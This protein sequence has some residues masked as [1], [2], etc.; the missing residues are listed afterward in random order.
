[1]ANLALARESQLTI[2][3]VINK[4]D[5][6]TADPQR[7][8]QQ[9]RDTLGLTAQPVLASAKE[10][11][12]V[13]ELLE[14]IV[15]DIPPPRGTATA[16]LQALVFDSRFD[17]YKGVVIY[18]RV[19]H[20]TLTPA[21]PVLLMGT[22]RAGDVQELG[23]LTPRPMAVQALSAGE[24]GYLTCNVKDPQDV[25]AGDTITSA[26]EPAREPLPGYKPVRPLVF[27]S[28][29]TVNAK[30]FPALR[31]ALQKLR[32]SDASFLFEPETSGP[33]GFGFRCGFLGLLH[34]EIIQERLEREF[35]LSLIATTPSVVYR[36]RRRHGAPCEINNPAQLPPPGDVTDIEEPTIRAV[37]IVPAESQGSVMHLAQE[38]RGVYKSTQYLGADRVMLVYK[39]PLIEV[40]VDFH[41]R[42]KS[43]TRGYG[44]MDYEFLG[45]ASAQLVKLDILLN[46][47]PC[48]ALASIVP[49]AKAYLRGRDLVMRLK[50]L[51]P[52][53]LFEVVIQAAIGSHVIAR[54]TVRPLGK[55]VTGRCSG[56]DITRKR[57]LWEK[58]REGKKRMKQFGKVEIP[59]EAFLAMLKMSP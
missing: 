51:I 59:Q 3:P 56:G 50:E 4:V 43:A 18:C 42:L 31:E 34:M 47:E 26:R 58:Q 32:L 55:H 48:S 2:I 23:V 29:Y 8:C 10:G 5:L 25:Q 57:K 17:V 37:L 6:S 45:Y 54:E 44:S 28:L 24:V 40:I 46:G 16:P 19:V 12:G 7:V 52:R 30:D 33:F 36:V 41:D 14:R 21:M 1:V 9:L 38:R 15:R 53:Q 11:L 13:P 39:F 27:C 20:G 35:G 49:K 22:K